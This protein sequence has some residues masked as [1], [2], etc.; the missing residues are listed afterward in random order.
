MFAIRCS[1][2]GVEHVDNAEQ[3]GTVAGTNSRWGGILRVHPLFFSDIF[4]DGYEAVGTLSTELDVVEDW[5]DDRTAA[6]V[7]YLRDQVVQGV[8]LWN[9]WDSVPAA[10]KILS[11][12]K[13]GTLSV[14]DLPGS[15]PVGD[16]V[17]GTRE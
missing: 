5:N 15:I 10:R 3:S 13:A 8:L 2:A 4:D 14:D 11:A 6:V 7:Y 16:G 12:S 1:V 17:G 9:T